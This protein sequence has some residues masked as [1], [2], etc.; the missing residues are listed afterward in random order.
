MKTKA[1]ARLL[2]SPRESLSSTVIPIED[3]TP[4]EMPQATLTLPEEAAV[5]VKEAV[6]E[7]AKEAESVTEIAA[8]KPQEA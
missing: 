8:T 3:Q 2:K 1:A 7:V 5:I 4:E 6:T